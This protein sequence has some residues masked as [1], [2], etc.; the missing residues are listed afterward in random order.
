MI[1]FARF[2]EIALYCPDCGYYEKEN[3]N[4][5]RRG[6][7]YTSVSVGPLFGHLLAFQFAK[8]LEEIPAATVQLVE[9]GRL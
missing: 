7:F 9:A 8:W 2:M 6:D 4:I 1:P 5:G 3:D